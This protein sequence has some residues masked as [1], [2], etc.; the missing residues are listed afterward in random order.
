MGVN[1]PFGID[2]GHDENDGKQRK[3][4]SSSDRKMEILRSDQRNH[5]PIS[6]YK[7]LVGVAQL[8]VEPSLVDVAR[9]HLTVARRTTLYG[10]PGRT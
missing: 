2:R 6:C 9:Y 5:L 10:H 4:K 1:R 7:P 8:L 3:Q